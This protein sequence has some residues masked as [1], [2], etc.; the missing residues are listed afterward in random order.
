MDNLDKENK[1]LGGRPRK[2]DSPEHLEGLF[3]EYIDYCKDNALMAN[4]SGFCTFM[5]RVKLIS[6]HRD[7][8]YEY[9]HQEGYSDIIKIINDSLEDA[10]L[11]TKC[12]KDLIKIAYLNNKCGYTQKQDITIDNKQKEITKEDEEEILKKYGLK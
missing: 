8:Y 2:F 3:F 7:T 10:V 12:Q 6:M 5:R 1:N 4:I 11:N 9:S